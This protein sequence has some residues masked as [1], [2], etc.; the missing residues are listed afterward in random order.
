MKISKTSSIKKSRIHNSYIDRNNTVNKPNAISSITP[1]KK[2]QNTVYYSSGNHLMSYDEYYDSLRELKKEYKK[3]Y[4]DEQLLEKTIENFDE[5]KEKLLKNMKELLTKYNTAILSLESFDK[6][7]NTDN[8]KKIKAIIHSFKDKLN[9]LGIYIVR[10]KELEIDDKIFIDKIK[11][12]QNALDFLFEP[13]KG[14]I[15]KIY[16]AFK[17]IK[18]P[19][20][21]SKSKK[22]DNKEYI[23][24]ILDDRK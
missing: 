13:A 5:N 1:I 23:G 24:L 22:Y 14:L 4:H 7:F 16:Y 9:N 18:V 6:A 3:F 8:V 17:S 10:D 20:K 11:K 15:L 19:L 12:S 21:D 2:I